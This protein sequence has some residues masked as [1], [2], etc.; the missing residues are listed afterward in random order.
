MIVL[1]ILLWLMGAILF[2]TNPNNDETRWASLIA[3]F[4]GFG[5]LGTVLGDSTNRSEWIL[6]LDSISTSFGHYMT[7]YAIL[8]FGLV[9]SGIFK[10]SKQGYL[11]KLLLMIPVI[12]M[13]Y[14]DQ[15]YPIFK[16]HYTILAIWATPYVLGSNILLLYTTYRETRPAIKRNKVFTCLVIVPMN[17]FA[18][19]T[20]IIL[21]ALNIPDVWLY[22]PWV[23]ILQFILFSYFIIRYGFLDVQIKF[24]K[25]KRDSTM[26]SITSGTALLNHTVKNE[27]AKIDMLINEL[28]DQVLLQSLKKHKP[29]YKIRL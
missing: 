21:E 25:Q 1:V 18:L 2:L 15:L 27:I 19:F 12:I 10:T 9:F 14:I 8:I 6:W 28:K 3:F 4:G 24:E 13:Y 5:G 22:N 17:T 20:N 23:I 26:K 11:W 29:S 7:P 16:A